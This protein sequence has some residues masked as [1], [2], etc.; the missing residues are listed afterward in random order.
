MKY[1]NSIYACVELD[2][3]KLLVGWTWVNLLY[4]VI[5]NIEVLQS[6]QSCLIIEGCS[7]FVSDLEIY[8][9]V[10]YVKKKKKKKGKEEKGSG[11]YRI[12]RAALIGSHCGFY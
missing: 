6:D 7:V 11:V 5:N 4:A 3:I 9:W 2:I 1:Y 8:F 12:F 10:A